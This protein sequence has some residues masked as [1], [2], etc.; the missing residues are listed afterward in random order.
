MFEGDSLTVIFGLASF[1]VAC[2]IG[3]LTAVE[4]WKT[5]SLWFATVIFVFMLV[6]WIAAP[7]LGP[8]VQAA[9]PVVGSFVQSGAVVMIGTVAIVALMTKQKTKI[10][11]AEPNLHP[12]H[13]VSPQV[14]KQ[15]ADAIDRAD[16][17]DFTPDPS[18][19]I[20]GIAVLNS[21]FTTLSKEFQMPTPSLSEQSKKSL[22]Y[23][24]RFLRLVQP[25]LEAGHVD[26]ANDAA[27][28]F[29]RG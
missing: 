12:S 25:Y 18:S 8:A 24:V 22:V 9:K 13:N 19:I 11:I 14:R 6:A 1:V 15:I 2:V 28:D 3:A 4:G 26:E 17:E 5:T 7:A 16:W 29:L 27:A 21:A 20:A 23:G 10:S